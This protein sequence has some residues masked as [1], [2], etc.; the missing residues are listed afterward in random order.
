MKVYI[1]KTIDHWN[2]Q[3]TDYVVEGRLEK[4]ENGIAVLRDNDG[5]RQCINLYQI[6]CLVESND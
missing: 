1:Y 6:F 2:N 4:M 5:N 3:T